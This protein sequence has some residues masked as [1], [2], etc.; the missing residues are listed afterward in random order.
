MKKIDLTGGHG[1]FYLPAGNEITIS[2]SAGFGIK[3]YDLLNDSYNKCAV[4]SIELKIDSNTIYRYVMDEF[5]FAESRY[6]NSHIDYETY[7]KDRVYFERTYLLPGDRLSTYESLVNNGIYTF[8]DNKIHHVV[9]EIRDVRNNLS[10]LSFT[11]KSEPLV[12]TP[13]PDN[14]EPGLI[15]MPYSRA[16]RF[17]AGNI[18]VSIP[19]GALYDTLLFSY[20]K[21]PPGS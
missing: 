14:A 2:G 20:R 15:L 16:N 17:R 5:S 19:A 1:N 18:A 3:T 12:H 6:I 13:A 21:E 10:V 4:Y 9:I 7:M 8:R 11:V